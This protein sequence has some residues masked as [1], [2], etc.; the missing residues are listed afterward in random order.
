MAE[1]SS[2]THR[3]QRGTNLPSGKM[4]KNTNRDT[5][6]SWVKN[7]ARLPHGEW[8]K[9]ESKVSGQVSPKTMSEKEAKRGP[10]SRDLRQKMTAP[11]TQKPSA[12]TRSSAST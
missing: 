10:G 8:C 5:S 12:T 11:T 4:K 1:K 9:A 6:P 3:L 7:P 2:T